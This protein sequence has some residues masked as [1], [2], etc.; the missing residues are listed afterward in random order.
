MI[1]KNYAPS[2]YDRPHMFTVGW[3]YE[4]PVGRGKQFD[5]SNKAADYVIGGWK[6]SGTFVAYSG[7]PFTMTGSGA[8]LQAVGNSQTADQIGPVTKLDGKGP[9][10][11]F[12]DPNSF[13]DPLVYQ[14]AIKASTGQT[15]YRFGSMGRNSL[16]GPGYWQLNP[17][18]YKNFRFKE[19][20][21]AEFRIESTNFT[22]T[23]IW[24]N[25]SGSSAAPV[26]KADGT[27]DM[28]A[29]NPLRNFMCITSA[30]AGRQFRFGLRVAF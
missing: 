2:G 6:F 22:N 27:I 1:Y 17:G 13:V 5:I 30:T 18:I 7:L 8:S 3:N 23:P 4:L 28:S 14:N 21:N 15:I 19:K 16:R 11:P 25:P 29:T 12:F 9:G 24:G 10:Q 26:R 20:V